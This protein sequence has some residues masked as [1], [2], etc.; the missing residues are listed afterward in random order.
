MPANVPVSLARQ[1]AFCFIPVMDMY[2]AYKVKKL[3]LY[4]LIMI[5][6]SLALGAIGGIINPPPES[7]DSELYRDDF[8]NIDWNKVWFGQNPE[9]SISFMIL[10]IA[11][12][13]ALAIFLIRKWSKKW[14]EQIAN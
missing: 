3:R 12:T 11:I 1:T 6:L 14:N 10:N 9:F 2:A 5:G 8:G 7:N 13:L 4:L